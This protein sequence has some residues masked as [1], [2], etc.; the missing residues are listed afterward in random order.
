MQALHFEDFTVGRRFD[1]PGATLTEAEIVSFALT[2]DPQP[3]HIDAEAAR[4]T[5]YG[6]LIA[7]GFQT[8]ALGFRLFYQTGAI[9]ACSL[10]AGGL[11][12]L[13]WQLPVRPGDTLKVAVE[14]VEQRPSRSRPDRGTVR[15]LYRVHNQ[16]GELVS[17][18]IANHILAKRDGTVA[19]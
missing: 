5:P 16:R 17:S 13:R 11:D 6:G 7:S 1:S 18:W 14:V 3:F 19:V 4:H 10:G 2:Y 8:L 9:A 12:E 15:M